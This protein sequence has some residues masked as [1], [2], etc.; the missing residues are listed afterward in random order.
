MRAHFMFRH[1][2]I[3]N[4]VANFN[5]TQWSKLYPLEEGQPTF[6]KQEWTSEDINSCEKQISVKNDIVVYDQIK[7]LEKQIAEENE[8]QSKRRTFIFDAR[9]PGRFNGTEPEPR[10]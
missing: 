6:S 4:Y 2:G 7:E 9:A 1:F 10:P 3:D 5:T 8:S